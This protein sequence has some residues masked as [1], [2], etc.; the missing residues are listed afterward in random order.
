MDGVNMR[1]HQP[2]CILMSS[3]TEVGGGDVE[4]V[5]DHVFENDGHLFGGDL[6]GYNSECSEGMVPVGITNGEASQWQ[7]SQIVLVN[8]CGQLASK[9]VLDK[10]GWGLVIG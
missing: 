2:G 10:C 3:D 9:A 6:T 5:C 7:I 1:E 8:V 4:D